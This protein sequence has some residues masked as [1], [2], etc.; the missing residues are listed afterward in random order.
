MWNFLK[1]I[2]YIGLWHDRR[3]SVLARK[4]PQLIELSEDIEFTIEVNTCITMNEITLKFYLQ[5]FHV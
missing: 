4:R 5:I 1:L 2:I 3:T